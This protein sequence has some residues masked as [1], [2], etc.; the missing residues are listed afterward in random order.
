M[1]FRVLMNDFPFIHKATLKKLFIKNDYDYVVT[2]QK[3]EREL[4]WAVGGDVTEDLQNHLR[5]TSGFSFITSGKRKENDYYINTYI[6][7]PI[8]MEQ[9]EYAK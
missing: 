7:N 3:L 9:R 2:R 1:I 4:D 8:L 5:T 6:T